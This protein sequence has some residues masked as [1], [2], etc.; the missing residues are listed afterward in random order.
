MYEEMSRIICG[1]ATMELADFEKGMNMLLV[2][3]VNVSFNNG[4]C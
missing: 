3:G 1:L 2:G 4:W